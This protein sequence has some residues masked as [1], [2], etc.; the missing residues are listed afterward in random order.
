M[1]R[2]KGK[3]T[4]LIGCSDKRQDEGKKNTSTAI[5]GYKTELAVRPPRPCVSVLL[6]GGATEGAVPLA[7]NDPG[8]VETDK[9]GNYRTGD[10]YCIYGRPK[11]KDCL[12]VF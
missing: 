5:M 9:H 3:V 1:R 12:A 6:E 10:L 8:Q 4:R 7:R 11:G 2:E